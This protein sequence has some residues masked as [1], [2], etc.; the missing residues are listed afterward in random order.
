MRIVVLKG[1]WSPEREV[2]LNSGAFV[3][4]ELRSV[5]HDVHEID[6]IKDLRYI[7]DS[8]YE[9]SP[10]Y[11]VNMLHGIGGEDGIIQGILEVFG[12]PYSGSGVLGSSLAFH[13]SL[14]KMIV[15]AQG[16]RVI[17]GLDIHCH[18]IQQ[19]NTPMGPQM[20]YPFVVKPAANGSSVG[21][22]LV[23][24]DRDL[25]TLKN[26]EWTFGKDVILENYI[27]G[28][29]FTVLVNGGKAIG[30][31]EIVPNSNFYDYGSK[32]NEGGSSHILDFELEPALLDQML[33]AAEIAFTACHCRS[34]ARVDFRVDVN[35]VHTQSSQ[36]F[37]AGDTS[38][39]RRSVLDLLIIRPFKTSS[40]STNPQASEDRVYFLEINTQP[41]MTS[42][43]LVP[44]I[45][46]YN[47]VELPCIL[48][49]KKHDNQL[50]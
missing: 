44:E 41:G 9:H 38:C 46:K 32:Y 1:G 20:Q 27:A 12:V 39:S 34:F 42:T 15:K 2:S 29:E 4:N 50:K 25:E 11:I 14:C 19:I 43:S 16:V 17:D 49:I 37:G 18:D 36:E 48:N 10:D 22:F 28:R 23:F 26:T 7:T 33:S 6:V 8:L 35:H 31:L 21:V 5:G 30:A 3:S 40:G 24:N 47:H 45:A 13:K